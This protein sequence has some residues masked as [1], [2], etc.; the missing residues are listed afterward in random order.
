M[1]SSRQASSS[2]GMLCGHLAVFSFLLAFLNFPGTGPPCPV[3]S[4]DG[5]LGVKG[6]LHCVHPYVGLG[7]C[8]ELAA[9]ES[10]IH[11]SMIFGL[12]WVVFS[13]VRHL[14]LGT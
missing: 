4:M 14:A 3:S 7:D 9:G 2:S 12:D 6:V 13:S 11:V 5:W 1:T 10:H 8:G